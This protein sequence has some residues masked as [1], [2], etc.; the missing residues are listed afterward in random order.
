MKINCETA[1]GGAVSFNPKHG[2]WASYAVA[3]VSGSPPPEILYA[4]AKLLNGKSVQFFLNRETGLIV[5]DLIDRSG[6]GG[7]EVL[8]MRATSG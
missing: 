7:C 3:G 5:V 2:V 6:K 4:G 8:R 1:K